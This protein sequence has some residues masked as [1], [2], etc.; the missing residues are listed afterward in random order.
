MRKRYF[1]LG[2]ILCLISCSEEDN[3]INQVLNAERG[4]FLRT[5]NILQGELYVNQPNSTFE[6]ELEEMDSADGGLLSSVDV[7]L[8]FIDNTPENNTSTSSNLFKTYN[9]SDFT[10]G[11]NN[12]PVISLRYTY[13]ELLEA[14]GLLI[15]ETHCKDQFRLDLELNLTDGRVFKH[16]NAANSVVH[17]ISFS[18]SPFSYLINIVDPVSEDLFLGEYQMVHIEDGFFGPTFLFD[19]PVLIEQGHS[20]NVRTFELKHP[21]I[22]VRGRIVVEFTIACDASIVTK[23]IRAVDVCQ[24]INDA[25]NPPIETFPPEGGVI[26]PDIFFA[27]LSMTDDT[28]FELWYVEGFEGR[29]N[30]CDYSDFPAKIRLTKQ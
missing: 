27:P 13:T 23:Y 26:G 9:A 8:S 11:P 18:R 21:F 20:T 3:V 19:Q 2:F 7:Y 4:A 30:G 24:D 29:S 1:L 28:V 12:L 6:I 25:P 14:V 22:R 10:T 15:D 16:E 17:T 5:S